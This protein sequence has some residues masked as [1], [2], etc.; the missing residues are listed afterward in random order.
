MRVATFGDAGG[1]RARVI[2]RPS[3]RLL[4]RAA[5]RRHRRLDA[6]NGPAYG[7]RDLRHDGV[8]I[9]GDDAA[10]EAMERACPIAGRSS[11]L[12]G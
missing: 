9:G 2:G 10:R 4:Y 11:Q 1:P 6:T 3:W 12:G 5:G 8:A 7:F